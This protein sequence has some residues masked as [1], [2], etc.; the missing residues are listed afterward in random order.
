RNAGEHAR[1][2]TVTGR[3]GA[4]RVKLGTVVIAPKGFAK[5]THT[6][7][8]AK[9]KLWSTDSPYLYDASLEAASGKTTLQ[10][11]HRKVG[12]RSIKV[13][14]D[15]RLLLNGRALNLRGV[16]IQEDSRA[17]GFAI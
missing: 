17:H 8:V 2:V 7:R 14:A 6:L 13:T 10:R 3:F 11:F 1:R 15:G 12:V 16:G 9:P 4:K 5:L